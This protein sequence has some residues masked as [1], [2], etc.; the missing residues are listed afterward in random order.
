MAHFAQ[1]KSKNAE[2]FRQHFH[3][4]YNQPSDYNITVLDSLPQ[5]ETVRG[6]D[7]TPTDDEISKATIKLKNTA[8]G[9]SGITPQIWKVLLENIDTQRYL[10]TIIK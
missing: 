8:P 9:E 7:H 3:E 1:W 2:V 5:H 4:L 6:C 10:Q